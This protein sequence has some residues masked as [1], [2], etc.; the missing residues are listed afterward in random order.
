MDPRTSWAMS[1][2]R[3]R[4]DRSVRTRDLAAAVNLSCRHFSRLFR[5]GTGSS[6]SEWLKTSRMQAAEELL[7]GTFLS[8]KEVAGRIGMDQSHFT[9]EFR[10]A[11]GVCPR[12]WRLE[13]QSGSD[14][15]EIAK[16]WPEASR[17]S[18]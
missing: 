17:N 5:K 10:A 13:K 3:G 4:L 1:H 16:K 2:I 18:T 8:I 7:I 11:H 14:M 6:F 12:C 9:R 15:A